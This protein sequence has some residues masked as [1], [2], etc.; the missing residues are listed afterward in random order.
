[1]AE[2]HIYADFPAGEITN[3]LVDRLSALP[4][5]KFASLV[6]TGL[7]KTS[8]DE[9]ETILQTLSYR[10]LRW[11]LID[12]YAR[13]C[14]ASLKEIIYGDNFPAETEY[15]YFDQEAITL[16]N[17]LPTPI[18]NGAIKVMKATFQNPGFQIPMTD[19][20]SAKLLAI[21]MIGDVLPDYIPEEEK[22][23]YTTDLNEELKRLH[24]KSKKSRFVF[25]L[26]Y[27]LDMCRYY[28]V[29]PHWVFSLKGKLL[30]KS[31]V[32][33]I[34][35]D[36]FCLLSKTQQIATLEMLIQLN[37]ETTAGLSKVRIQQIR[38]KMQQEGGHI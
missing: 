7:I 35:F 29:S 6:R 10:N 12:D 13:A 16:L 25:H 24:L 34:A 15:S 36:H 26:D 37:A 22:A 5:E 31:A 23:Q 27:I 33:D 4:I 21:G 11:D 1:M 14:G 9:E 18:L 30:C 38:K 32:A 28:R 3:R 19:T 20:P 8:K 17:T 2:P